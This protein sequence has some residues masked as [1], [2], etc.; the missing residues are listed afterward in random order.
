MG[1]ATAVVTNNEPT[2]EDWEFNMDVNKYVD[3][4]NLYKERTASWEENRTKAYY[5][6]LQHCPPELKTELKNST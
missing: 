3:F 2:K 4:N 5:L 1:N 6:V